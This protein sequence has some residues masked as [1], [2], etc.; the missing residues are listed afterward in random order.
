[1]KR[2]WS[3]TDWGSNPSFTI[4]SHRQFMYSS[5]QVS[6]LQNWKGSLLL[7]GAMLANNQIGAQ[8]LAW[9]QAH[10]ILNRG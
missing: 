6:S 4:T 10:K 3:E 2:T 5:L 1:M 8:S 9:F 7:D